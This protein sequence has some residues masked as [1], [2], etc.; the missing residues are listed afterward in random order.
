AGVVGHLEHDPRVLIHGPQS[1]RALNALPGFF[2]RSVDAFLPEEVVTQFAG[3]PVRPKP[4]NERVPRLGIPP[5]NCFSPPTKVKSHQCEC[6]NLNQRKDHLL[7]SCRTAGDLSL[8]AIPGV[9][10][11]CSSSFTRKAPLRK[12]KVTSRSEIF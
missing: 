2:R 9:R 4:D 5:A 12:F 10:S 3:A 1:V 8:K 6:G 11:N 7:S